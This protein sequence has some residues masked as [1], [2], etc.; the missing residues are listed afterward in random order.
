MLR[1]KSSLRSY[2]GRIVRAGVPDA[3]GKIRFAATSWAM[4]GA[5]VLTSAP[6]GI[7]KQKNWG[8][9]SFLLALPSQRSV[10]LERERRLDVVR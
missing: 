7:A 3:S 6:T 10:F 1:A 5:L 4:P 9:K 8:G 2:S